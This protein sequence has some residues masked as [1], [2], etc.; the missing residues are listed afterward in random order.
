MPRRRN[1]PRSTTVHCSAPS[2]H[3]SSIRSCLCTPHRLCRP[4]SLSSFS[5]RHHQQL[6]LPAGRKYQHHRHHKR[7]HRLTMSLSFRCVQH[8]IHHR[9]A[10]LQVD[11]CTVPAPNSNQESSNEGGSPGL[12][13]A[14]CGDISSGKHYGSF[15]SLHCH[16][17]NTTGILACNGCSGFFK[18]S[19]RRKLIYRLLS[20]CCLANAQRIGAKRA[21]AVV[22][23]TRRTATSVRRVA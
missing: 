13:C 22:L 3:H 1:R 2:D 15:L 12:V 14:V 16:I 21:M 18:R 7:R 6:Q 20:V 23:S 5:H 9:S 8:M 17:V 11:S 10:S 4:V 19:V